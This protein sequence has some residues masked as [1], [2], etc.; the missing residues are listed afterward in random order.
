MTIK[1]AA[2]KCGIKYGTAKNIVSVFR[3]E[4]R[5]EKKKLRPQIEER[6]SEES[7]DSTIGISFVSKR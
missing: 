2:R 4:G 5:T 1:K 7:K 3:K 6:K